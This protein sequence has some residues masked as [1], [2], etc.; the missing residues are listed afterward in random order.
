MLYTIK[1]AKLRVL[2]TLL[3]TDVR[4]V[5][6]ESAEL[7]KKFALPLT[8]AT[9][10]KQLE[11]CKLLLEYGE[12]P[13]IPIGTMKRTA[14]FYAVNQMTDQDAV[15]AIV[16]QLVEYGAIKSVMDTKRNRPATLRSGRSMEGLI[17]GSP[18]YIPA[19]ERT[20]K[21]MQ[22]LTVEERFELVLSAIV[23]PLR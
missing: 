18:G 2:K 8:A 7:S 4:K 17:Y 3:E 6:G 22:E 11:A 15:S 10:C 20:L 13:N 19:N 14:L 21:Y 16:D 5:W 12:N 1:D 23:A 9:S